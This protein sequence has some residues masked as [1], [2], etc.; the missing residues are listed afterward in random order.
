MINELVKVTLIAYLGVKIKKFTEA[1]VDGF[2][3][4]KFYAVSIRT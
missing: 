4:R 1:E 2:S 3:F